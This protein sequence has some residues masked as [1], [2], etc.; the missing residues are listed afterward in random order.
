MIYF[1][2]SSFYLYLFYNRHFILILWAC[3]YFYTLKTVQYRRIYVPPALFAIRFF[4][5]YISFIKSFQSSIQFCPPSAPPPPNGF[6]FGPTQPDT[7]VRTVAGS[8]PQSTNIYRVQSSVWRLPNY[9]PPTPLFTQGVCPLS[10]PKAGG[11]AHTC[12]AVRGGGVNRKT[13]D[14]GLASYSVIPL[15]SR[16]ILPLLLYWILSNTFYIKICEIKSLRI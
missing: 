15:R 14:I 13:P 7:H 10:A 16:P 6:Y 11:G 4:P 3:F 12:R 5:L 1:F 2:L 8:R 9:W